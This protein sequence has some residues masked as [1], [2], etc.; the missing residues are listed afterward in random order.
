MNRG[1]FVFAQICAF[2]PQRTF[3]RYVEKYDGDKHIKHF[4]CWHQMLC[5]I[6]GQLSG[7][8]SLRDL[9]TCLSAHSLKYYQL[10]LGKNVSRSNLAYANENRNYRI[11]EEF[12]YALVDHARRMNVPDPE[13]AV[14]LPKNRLY[15]FDST[16]V[17]LCL[18][19]FCWATFRQRKAA[20]KMHTLFD[21]RAEIPT[22]I[23]VTAGSVHDVKALDE[24]AIEGDA[25]YIMDRAYVDYKRLWRICNNKAWFVVRA[26]SNMKYYRVDSDT[27]DRSSS[28]V[29]DQ[30]IVLTSKQATKDYP[31]ELRRV[32]Y[33]DEEND[34]L[35]VFLTNNFDITAEQVALLYKHRWTVET[36]FK[37]VKQH[38]RVLSFWGTTQ[39]AVKTQVFIAMITFIL[40]SIVKKSLKSD[41]SLNDI[42]QVLS[43]SLVDKTPLDVLLKDY[44]AEE[45]AQKLQIQLDFAGN[46]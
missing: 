16:V 1:K 3:R 21:V 36:F 41:L 44:M 29:C 12:A 8:E 18:E 31:S 37:W 4:S 26:K 23:Y 32:K 43:V 38:L 39:N 35:L 19:V 42:L 14:G 24:L 13:V 45:N 46:I 7:R 15:S 22:F 17:D 9:T 33:Y 5:M 2:L 10:G 6:F 20:I 34:L 27:V 25:F 28:I 40:V 30:M 11:F